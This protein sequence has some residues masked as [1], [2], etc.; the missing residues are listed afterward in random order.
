MLCQ[1]LRKHG[2]K[3]P[4]FLAKHIA[5]YPPVFPVGVPSIRR[6]FPVRPLSVKTVP[7]KTSPFEGEYQRTDG[8]KER[9][10]G[11]YRGV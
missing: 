9:E 8:L 5:Y 2:G 6:L 11:G 4:Q 1:V 10:D 7:E 3:Q